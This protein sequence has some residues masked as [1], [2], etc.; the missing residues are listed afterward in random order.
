MSLLTKRFVIAKF[1]VMEATNVAT[2]KT[3][4]I[5]Q[6]SDNGVREYTATDEQVKKYRELC[7]EISSKLMF[8]RHHE[9]ASTEEIEDRNCWL[10]AIALQIRPWPIR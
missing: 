4:A 2:N 7:F 1:V 3:A 9:P 10:E 5:I 6:V 8:V